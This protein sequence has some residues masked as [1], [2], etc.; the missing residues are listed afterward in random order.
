MSATDQ[1][2]A[3]W[4]EEFRDKLRWEKNY[5]PHTVA[6][7]TRDI[8]QFIHWLD[9]MTIAFEHVHES[10][11]RHYAAHLFRK[12]RSARSIQRALS[13]LRGFYTHLI[14]T[15]R[16][17]DNPIDGVRSPRE[18]RTLPGVLDVD[19]VMR[20]L[21]TECNGPFECRDLAMFELL[22]SSGMRLSELIGL[23]T[24]DLDLAAGEV[25]VLG[26]GRV[27]RVLPV[28]KCAVAALGRWLEIRPEIVKADEPA[29]F[30]SRYG[31]R[32]SGRNVQARLRQFGR[33]LGSSQALYPHL[34]RHSFASH[35]LESSG[36]LRAVQELL[37]HRRISTTQIYTHL[38]FQHLAQTYD[39]AHP[40]ARRRRN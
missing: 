22:Y 40:R 32:Q 12:G 1:D 26:K 31:K 38:N 33:K 25:R 19:A 15:H 35:L 28:G 30:V 7:Y 37:G 17:T 10:E 3:A 24:K 20:M 16:C 34:L 29:L 36:D 11:V 13:S 8:G 4:L 9:H 27:E 23:D 21:D 2:I 39:A 14:T 5:S 18:A 6:G